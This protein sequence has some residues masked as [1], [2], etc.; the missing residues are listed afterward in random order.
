MATDLPEI[1]D[2]LRRAPGDHRPELFRITMTG[3]SPGLVGDFEPSWRR[4]YPLTAADIAA[5]DE[6]ERLQKMRSETKFRARIE[7]VKTLRQD[8][9]RRVPGSRW[10]VNTSRWV[11]P[12]LPA[13][14]T[15]VCEVSE[16]KSKTK[17]KR[18]PRENGVTRDVSRPVGLVGAFAPV[19]AGTA[20]ATV[21]AMGAKG[22]HTV[23]AIAAKIGKERTTV[24]AHLFY[25]NRDCGI[26]YDVV[27]GK[28]TVKFPG[29]KT[30][31][32]AIKPAAE[33]A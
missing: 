16:K 22:T 2:F 29:S 25:L 30:V 15:G 6:V 27:D 23:D 32:D 10:D 18:A 33:A 17:A 14:T 8:G 1:P 4:A 3:S 9:N 5:R 7:R 21:I 26:G 31:E 20:R 24:M 28:L 11:H 12:G 19:R 13:I